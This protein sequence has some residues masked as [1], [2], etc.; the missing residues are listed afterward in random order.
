MSGLLNYTSHSGCSDDPADSLQGQFPM[1]SVVLMDRDPNE[2]HFVK[3]VRAAEAANARAVLFRNNRPVCGEKGTRCENCRTPNSACPRLPFLADDGKGGDVKI[4]SMIIE[5]SAGEKLETE[6]AKGTPVSVVLKWN[7]PITDKDGEK[8]AAVDFFYSSNYYSAV[9]LIQRFRV[10]ASKL[11]G[12]LRFQPHYYI[13]DG[14]R[15]GCPGGA[16]GSQ[17]TNNGRYCEP[18]PDQRFGSKFEGKHVVAENLRQMCAWKLAKQ[19][20]DQALWWNYVIAFN[21]H[22]NSECAPSRIR[23]SAARL[24]CGAVPPAQTRTLRSS[25][26]SAPTRSST[27]WA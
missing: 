15:Y 1:Q 10:F 13:Y 21:E 17:C 7:M 4:P 16:C 12:S 8:M 26:A 23:A 14:H 19:E 3:R 2:C 22:C 25:T 18:D 9:E 20:N 11:G 24:T 6:L 27:P 5:Q